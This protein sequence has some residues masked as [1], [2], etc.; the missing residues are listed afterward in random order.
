MQATRPEALVYP[1][2]PPPPASS[3]RPRSWS[4]WGLA[5]LL[6]LAVAGFYALGLYRYF[7]WAYLRSHL[8]Q[9]KAEVRQHLGMAVAIFF[10]VYVASTALSLPVATILTLIGGALF[11]RWLGTG[12]VSLSSTLGATLAMLASRYVLRDLVQRRL[13]GRFEA[14]QRGVDRDGAYYLLTL[15]MVPVF[16]FFL[17]NLGMGLTRMPARTFAAVSWL[18]ML[19]V[20]FVYVNAGTELARIEQP[21]DVLSP[22]LLVSLALVGLVPLAIRLLVR[23]RVRPRS[24]ALA[25]GGLVLALV[26][27]AGVRTHFRYA[28]DGVM[29]VPVREFTN[30][31]YPE[32]PAERSDH[33][34]QYDGRKLILVQKDDAHFDFILEPNHPH[35]ARV[36]FRDV[37]VRA[38][39]PSLPEWTKADDGLRRIAL[40]DRQWNRQQV[41]FDPASPQVEV[42][43]GDAFEGINLDS[44]ELAKNCLNAGLWEVLLYT[45]EHDQKALYYQGWFTFPLGHYKRIFEQQTGLP[46]WKHWYY[47]EHWFDPA[48]TPVALDGLRRVVREREVPVRF[49]RDEKVIA[50]GEQN[51]KRREMITQNVVKWEDFYDGRKVCFASFIPPGRYSVSRPWQNHY[52]RLA[53]LDKAL[54]RE[55]V[56]PAQTKPLSEIEFIFDGSPGGR[57]RF[58]V[59]GFDPEALPR[60][61]P[62]D[63]PKGLYMPMGIGVPPFFQSYADLQAAPPDRSPYFSLMLDDEGRWIDH[64][65]VAVDG[66]VMHRDADDPDLLHIYLLSYERHSLIGHFVVST[67]K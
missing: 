17:V 47:L 36:V 34:G 58:V 9:L 46:Y 28:V 8:D 20:T 56:S 39:T 67:R 53:R 10:A 44:A 40:T 43:G 29:E 35:I 3:P 51:R 66:P 41:R 21:S 42:T 4:R 32:D 18:G 13:G 54:L 60:L 48:G 33:F 30:A 16:P 37:D 52:G 24:V 49:D 63:Y 27:A 12:V 5:G 15:R 59:S 61:A 2:P 31:D 57:C 26:V 19:P 1:A 25:L 45:R 23:W 6:L 14:L 55:V 22:G 7:D 65:S 62:R 11:E 50:A 38:M 64:H